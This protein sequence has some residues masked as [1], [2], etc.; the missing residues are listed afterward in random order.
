MRGR[1]HRR[2]LGY[3]RGAG[4]A[5]RPRTASVLGLI[6]RR[7][8]SQ[9]LPGNAVSY[10]V[11]VTDEARARRGGAGLHPPLRRARPGDRQR[12]HRERHQRRG[13]ARCRQAAED[14]RGQRRRP[15]RDARRIRAGDARS[16]ARHACRHRE[17]RWLPRPGRQRRLLRLEVGGDH[18][19][20][21]PARRA[22]RQ[23]RLG[24]LHLPGLHR[25]ADDA[26][27]PL[28]HAFPAVRR[29]SRAAHRAR[30]R[31]ASAGSR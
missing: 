21:K 6:S 19:D 22:L 1:H 3:R 27:Q 5:L 25:H 18:L 23:R 2:L 13:S 9:G 14:P 4:A 24:G 26:R 15:R 29:R 31:R 17:R 30:D 8:R 20:G 10:A 7:S 12:R 28:P 16:R 11:D